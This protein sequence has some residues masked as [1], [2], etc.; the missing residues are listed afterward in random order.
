M[1]I[2]EFLFPFYN[3]YH[4]LSDI[5]ENF[6]QL[7]EYQPDYV[8]DKR[9]KVLYKIN[10]N[11]R[12]VEK[13]LRITDFFS[14]P[15]RVACTFRDSISPL[16]FFKINKETIINSIGNC[17]TYQE[18]DSYL[19]GRVKQCSNFNVVVCLSVLRY[20][21][22]KKWLDPSAGWGDRLIAAISFGCDYRA[23]DPNHEMQQYYKKMINTLASDPSKYMITEEGFETADIERE[24]YDLVFTS[25]PFFDLEKYDNDPKQSHIK[26][27]SVD[28]WKEGFLYPLIIKSN[29]A[30]VKKGHLALYISDYRE[31][32]YVEDMKK[33]ISTIPTLKFKGLICWQADSRERN[34]MVWEKK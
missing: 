30:L 21:K 14:E 5:L 23:T 2:R 26:F 17:P 11:F 19:W 25:P 9:K 6:K 16:E 12:E 29:N 15:A 33:F 7:G 10:I 24:K 31:A 22:P 28:A 34:I 32:R 4:N 3:H 13:Y 8:R 18:I 27:N 1:D 20:F